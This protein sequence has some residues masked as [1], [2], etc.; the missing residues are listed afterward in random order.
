MERIKVNEYKVIGLGMV[1]GAIME[2]AM[3]AIRNNRIGEEEYDYSKLQEA[4][5]NIVERMNTDLYL[6]QV[7][8]SDDE[9]K[10]DSYSDIMNI[11]L[12][13]GKWM[14]VDRDNNN[15]YRVDD[16]TDDIYELLLL[17]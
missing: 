15:I 12:S 3:C 14:I 16:L 6:I 17:I 10:I 9:E 4:V 13:S 8:E 11:D 7:S 1:S 2:S 5:E